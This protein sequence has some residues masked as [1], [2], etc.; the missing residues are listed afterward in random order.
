MFPTFLA[1]GFYHSVG[2]TFWSYLDRPTSFSLRIG[3]GLTSLK[4]NAENL[5]DQKLL[6]FQFFFLEIKLNPSYPRRLARAPKKNLEKGNILS[7]L[8]C[9]NESASLKLCRMCTTT[10]IVGRFVATS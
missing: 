9:E 1:R 10:T 6:F 3:R 4:K 7:T 2:P 8:F 5:I